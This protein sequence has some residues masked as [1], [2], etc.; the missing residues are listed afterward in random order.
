M[1][2]LY[3]SQRAVNKD[4][5]TEDCGNKTQ[6]ETVDRTTEGTKRSSRLMNMVSLAHADIRL[7]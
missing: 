1:E 2:P 6:G 3:T 5:D 7:E 4:V